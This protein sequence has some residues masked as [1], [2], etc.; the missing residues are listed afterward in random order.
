[1]VKHVKCMEQGMILLQEK[2]MESDTETVNKSICIDK[3]IIEKI[4]IKQIIHELPL[5]LN[6][7]QEILKESPG[8]LQDFHVY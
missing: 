3:P 1:M 7:V 2:C 8:L 5:H 6:D 4:P